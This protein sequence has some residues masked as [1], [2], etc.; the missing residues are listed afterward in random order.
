VSTQE[1]LR[2]YHDKVARLENTNTVLQQD[3]E[4]AQRRTFEL[5]ERIAEERAR[6]DSVR[7]L[8]REV[9]EAAV[10]NLVESGAIS[11]LDRDNVWRR[12]WEAANG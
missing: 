5:S 1:V 2:Q 6:A 11:R 8:L 4:R 10:P 3:Y 9:I 12:A 7:P